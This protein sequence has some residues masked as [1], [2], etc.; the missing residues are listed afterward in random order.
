MPFSK[1]KVL[2]EIKREAF[3]QAHTVQVK[4]QS[5]GFPECRQRRR[6]QRRRIHDRIA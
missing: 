3:K 1:E 6:A 2:L 5:L 4:R